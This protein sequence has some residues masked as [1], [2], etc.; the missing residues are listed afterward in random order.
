MSNSSSNGKHVFS[1]FGVHGRAF[2]SRVAFHKAKM[3]VVD[4]KVNFKELVKRRTAPDGLD[5]VPLG[6][7][8]TLVLPNGKLYC[9][10]MAIA[11]YAGKKAGLY[12]SDPEQALAVDEILETIQELNDKLPQHADKDTRKQL[13]EAFLKGDF[14]RYFKF[15]EKR[16]KESNGPFIL[17]NEISIADL[18]LYGVTDT[19]N[20]GMTEFFPA[21]CLNQNKILMDLIERV[22]N[23]PIVVASGQVKSKM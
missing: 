1:Y 10:S 4:E 5:K 17:G 21:G 20:S 15:F 7:L 12:P 13:R 6:Q 16:I 23:H 8:P 9:Q 22:K 11:R 14:Q 2:V 19:Y 18:A 3:D